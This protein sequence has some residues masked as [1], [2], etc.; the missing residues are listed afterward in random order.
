MN[1]RQFFVGKAVGTL[2]VLCL[3]GLFFLVQYVLHAQKQE[4]VVTD[5]KNIEY[6]IE[7][8][9]VLLKD[10]SH[11]GVA[12]DGGS[13]KSIT[14][15][16]GNEVQ[17]DFNNDGTNDVAFLL[18]QETGGSG[19]F[20]YVALA[21]GTDEGYQGGSVLFLGDRIAPQSTE[22]IDGQ[23]VVN[24][25]E[26]HTGEAMVVEPSVGVS[27]YFAVSA[28]ELIEVTSSEEV[29][30]LTSEV[31]PLGTT[32]MYPQ[33]FGTTY[34]E[35]T[36]WPPTVVVSSDEYVCEV[37]ESL[38]EDGQFKRVGQRTID[39]HT[40]CVTDFAEGAAGST[41]TSYEYTTTQGDFLVSVSFTLRTVQCLNFDAQTQSMCLSAQNNFDVDALAHG[42]A[43]SITMI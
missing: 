34:V 12:I 17:A 16:F 13:S 26:R 30:W 38:S 20:Y 27:R 28:N 32:Y 8:E 6:L 24:Y 23:V 40:Y 25:A 43:E 42:I 36:A 35:A 33:N 15:Y 10:G 22:F 2:V 5:Y 9:R 41:F 31:S 39:G 4:I 29:A 11:E 3:V 18:T 1:L 21:V 7:G 37:N 19:I 14:R